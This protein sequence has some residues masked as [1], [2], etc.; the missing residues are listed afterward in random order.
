MDWM[1]KL[2]VVDNLRCSIYKGNSAE[3]LVEFFI[4]NQK[5]ITLKLRI[6]VGIF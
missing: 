1:G 4:N 5:K 6:Y 3:I 2:E